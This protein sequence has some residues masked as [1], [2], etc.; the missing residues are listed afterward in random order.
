MLSRV[1]SHRIKTDTSEWVEYTKV[2]EE[3]S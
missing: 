2:I 3:C 1:S